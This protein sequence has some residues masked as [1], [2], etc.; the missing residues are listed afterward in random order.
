[1]AQVVERV[2]ERLPGEM[3]DMRREQKV[4]LRKRR[5]RASRRKGETH[6]PSN[7]IRRESAWCGFDFE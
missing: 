3:G 2:R 4:D 7:F 5:K 6:E 1:V